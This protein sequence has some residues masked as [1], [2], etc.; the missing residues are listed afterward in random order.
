MAQTTTPPTSALGAGGVAGLSGDALHDL[1]RGV[2][3]DH[4]FRIRNAVD[5]SIVQ[6]LGEAGRQQA[7]R[8]DGATSTESWVVERY[9]VSKA[10]ARSLTHIAEIAWDLPHLVGSLCE[11]E[12]S[13]DKVRAL[14]D[15]A[16]PETERRVD[17]AGQG[18]HCARAGRHR[19]L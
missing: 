1:F 5:G 19:P 2:D 15:V 7:F 3:L 17:R 13:F 14:A 16:S 12:I 10:T 8:D 11:G 9:G 18:M 4:L 6:K